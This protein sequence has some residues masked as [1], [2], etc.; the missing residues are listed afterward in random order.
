MGV[1][2]PFMA[3]LAAADSQGV[4]GESVREFRD[5]RG[6]GAKRGAADQGS[7]S[8]GTNGATLYEFLARR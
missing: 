2:G 3:A 5:G 6:H 4:V 1:G 7:P 8:S